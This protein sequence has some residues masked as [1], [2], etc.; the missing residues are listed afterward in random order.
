MDITAETFSFHLP[1]LLDDL[2]TCHF[3][4]IDCE[5]SG[6]PT[7]STAPSSGKPTLQKRYDE[8]RTCADKYSILQIGL[9]VGHEDTRKGIHDIVFAEMY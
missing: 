7:A 6:I 3:V 5:F 2:A 1:R 8:Y 9:T 4:S